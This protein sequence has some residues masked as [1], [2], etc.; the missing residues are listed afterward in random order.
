MSSEDLRPYHKKDKGS[1]QEAADALAAVLTHAAE[2]DEAAEHKQGPKKQ[3]KWMLPLGVNLGV[4]AVYLL[5]AS[6]D[7]VV[8]NKIDSAPIA[9]QA[10]D[11]RL[12]IFMQASRV[13]VYRLQNGQLPA[14]LADA[15]SPVEGLSYNVIGPD[16]YELVVTIETEVLRYDSS[17]P[18]GEWVGAGAKDKLLGG[19][20]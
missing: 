4:F 2:R 9:E 19:T 11:M 10:E 7:W 1:G 20:G 17:Q 16:Q 8:M 18:V 15:G 14:S 3:S 12:A 6:P 13:D 5:I